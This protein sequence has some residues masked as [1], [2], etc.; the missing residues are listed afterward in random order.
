[1]K[2]VVAVIAILFSC[3]GAKAC[4]EPQG[5]REQQVSYFRSVINDAELRASKT[6]CVTSS[7]QVARLNESNRSELGLSSTDSIQRKVS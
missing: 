6:E 4:T 5:S 2:I 3:A 7:Y 1:M